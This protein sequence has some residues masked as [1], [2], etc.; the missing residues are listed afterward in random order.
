MNKVIRLYKLVRKLYAKAKTN[1]AK[2]EKFE[3]GVK[4]LINAKDD[5]ELVKAMTSLAFT[6]KGIYSPERKRKPRKPKITPEPVQPPASLYID[7]RIN[8]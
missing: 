6:I 2:Y 4:A 3:N 1:P 5:K 8:T 7:P